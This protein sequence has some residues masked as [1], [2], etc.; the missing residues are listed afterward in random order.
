MP[1]A[2]TS[3]TA[4]KRKVDLTSLP[5]KWEDL[6]ELRSQVAGGRSLMVSSTVQTTCCL[7]NLKDCAANH[8][9]IREVLNCMVVACTTRT[10]G[11]DLLSTACQSFLQLAHYPDET[12]L[13]AIG[14]RDA[15]GLKRCLSTLRRKWVRAERPKDCCD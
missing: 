15:W 9:A 12:T 6:R 11:I 5:G 4:P 2:M 8:A 10:P 13:N 7:G 1:A 14:H 3:E